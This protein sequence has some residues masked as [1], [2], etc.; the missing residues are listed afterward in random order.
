MV[1]APVVHGTRFFQYLCQRVQ[2]QSLALRREVDCEP[3]TINHHC[4]NGH[5]TQRAS[6][7]AAR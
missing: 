3:G 2:E 5:T 4:D 7:D 1:D 6:D